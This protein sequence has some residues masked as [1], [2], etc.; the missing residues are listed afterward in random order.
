MGGK[1][2]GKTMQNDYKY[3]GKYVGFANGCN[4]S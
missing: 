4:D 1:Y 2:E 3:D